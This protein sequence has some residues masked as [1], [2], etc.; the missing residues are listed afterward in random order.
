MGQPLTYQGTS[1][2][3][4]QRVKNRLDDESWEEFTQWYEPYIKSLLNRLNVPSQQVEDLC[5]DILLSLWKGMDQFEY[6]PDHCK[7]RSYLF[8]VTKNKVYTYF[9]SLK[10]KV[11]E[12]DLG[13]KDF[14]SEASEIDLVIEKEWQIYVGKKAFERV[15]EQFKP[16]ILE[17]YLAF[18]KGESPA[19]LAD[20]FDVAE[21]TIYV[22]NKRVKEAMTRAVILLTHELE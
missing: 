2:T 18:Q 11:K 12:I 6:N 3:L 17:I 13:E 9:K 22:Y 14:A 21:N 4:I 1:F 20:K 7:F 16:H 19:K 8:A 15:Q 5:Q 10:S